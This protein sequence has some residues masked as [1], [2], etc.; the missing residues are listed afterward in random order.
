MAIDISSTTRR[1]VYTG[2]AGVGPY[3]FAFEVLAQTDIAVYFNTTELTLTTDYTVSISGDG[4]GSVT[5]VTGS[6]VPS[7]P[8]SSD[9]ITIVGDRTI[10]RTTDFTTGGPLFATSLN[11]EFDSQT[12]FVQQ[13]LEQ[14]DRSLRAPNTDPTTINMTLPLNTVRANKTLAFDADGNPTTGE[15][16]GNWRGNWAASTD[17]SKRDLVKDTTNNNIYICVT[18]HTSSGSLPLTTNADYAKW[19]LMVDAASASGFADEAEAWA[20]KTDG[21]VESTDYSS[22]AWS[23]GGTGVTTTSG[24]GAAKEWA[25]STGAAVDTS[26]YSAKEYAQGNLTASGGSAKAWAEDASSPDGTT[27]KS[28]KTHASEA[29]T[30]ASNAS[31]SASAASSSASSASS[32]ASAAS[33]SASAAASSASAASSSATAAAASEA[34]A[35]AYTDNFDDT[36]LG[37]KASDPTLDNDGDALQDGALYF[38]TTNNVMKVYD[39]GTTTWYQL[40]PTVSNQTNINTVAGIASDVTT[41]AGISSNVTTV[42]G[43]S[44]N[45]TTVAGISGNVTTVAGDSAN[46]GTV[47]TDL[48]GTDTIGT[49]ATNISN[50]N[51]VGTNIA[52]VNTVGGIS[53]N[54]TTVAGISGNVTTVA[55]IS[56]DVT[57]V[58]GISSD[59]TTAATNITDISNFADVYYGPSATAPT[60][61]ADGSALQVGDLYFDT[62]TS[63]MKVYG[64]GGWVAAGSS[65]NGTADRYLYSV[66]SSTTTI[67]GVD[68]NGNT[69]AYDAGFVDVYLNGVKM[70]NGTDITATSGTSI[71][72]ASAIG[73]SGTDTVDI[74]AYGTFSLASFSIGDAANVDLGGLAT[75][76][77]LQYNGSNF[78]PKTFDEV[79]PSQATNAGKYLTTDGTN[80]SW[81][82]VNTDLVSDTTPQLGGTLDAN[83]NIIDMGVN[84]ITDTKVGQWDTA[85]GWGDHAT[86]GYLTGNETITLSGD[87]TGSGTTAITATLG[88]VAVSKGGTGQTTYT[89]G[90]L[91]IGNSTGN[92]LD[93]ATITAGSGISVTNG[94]GAITIAATGGGGFSN[95]DVI[96]SSG[97]WTNPGSVTKVKVTVVGGGGGGGGSGPPSGGTGAGG[98]GG[99]TAIEVITIPTSPVPVTIGGGGSAG[100]GGG[101]GSSGG[102]SS[103]STYCSAT[104]GGGGPYNY[105]SPGFG[106]GGSGSGGTLN[107]R[108]GDGNPKAAGRGGKS[109]GSYLAEGVYNPSDGVAGSV[110]AGQAGRSYGGGGSGGHNDPGFGTQS[111]G[112]GAAGVV[113]VE[114]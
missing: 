88:T 22:K 70:V 13:V 109:G 59:I 25:T 69:L 71:V 54:V 45:V 79:T 26:E 32:S 72:F 89:D 37:A 95:M 92:T 78:V 103:F 86:G 81:G 56:A 62:A 33:S 90:E 101:G 75:N 49:V 83:G 51:T 27:T 68:A 93:K 28:A 98:G 12:I 16:V 9:R 29:A 85:Y 6:S 64:S 52:N 34:A 113:I 108:G 107:F 74:I 66:S 7:T 82:T 96:T 47:A 31:S 57:T 91:L 110:A 60:L 41:V 80:S 76:D 104:G 58:A 61:R 63:T 8:T 17:Y 105:S 102:T 40:T 38:D 44:A 4:T 43:I 106:P 67:S 114:Y 14:S 3:A 21:I 48:S 20:T 97:T 35:A 18:A 94:A 24:K 84:T 42:S 77:L 46:I 73:T 100:P 112:A 53:S 87:V 99:G 36:Y 30:S 23:I 15:I 11:D 2:S 5:I 19:A 111:G 50:V 65:V 10:Q 55:G 39:L 1:I